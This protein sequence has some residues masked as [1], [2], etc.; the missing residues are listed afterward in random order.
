MMKT[1]RHF[2]WDA[3]QFRALAKV[4]AIQDKAERMQILGRIIDDYV[5][6]NK[7]NNQNFKPDVFRDACNPHIPREKTD[8]KNYPVTTPERMT[9][10]RV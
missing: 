6:E 3:A 10:E 7:K 2:R 4:M 9:D 1:R 8:L 5:Y